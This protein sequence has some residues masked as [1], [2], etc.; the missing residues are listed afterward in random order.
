MPFTGD[1]HDIILNVVAQLH[2]VSPYSLALMRYIP[3]DLKRRTL[4]TAS[5]M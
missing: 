1:D 4:T 2:R 5:L 3:I